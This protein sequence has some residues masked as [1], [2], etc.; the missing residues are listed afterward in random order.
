MMRYEAKHKFFTDSA[1]TSRNF[2]NITKTLSNRHQRYIS[3]KR[4]S[5]NNDIYIGKKTKLLSKYS[6]FGEYQE[7]LNRLVQC[8]SSSIKSIK[9]ININSNEYR[10]GLMILHEK[11]LFEIVYV[12][13]LD[14]NYFIFCHSYNVKR[15]D[16]PMN[17]FIIEKSELNSENIRLIQLDD[18]TFEKSFEKK[19]ANQHIYLIAESLEVFANLCT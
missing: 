12:L 11:N 14:S 3:T 8:D 19:Y 10:K 4:F 17:S 13:C 16:E 15:Y 7:L 2:I 18:L 9:F 6:D 5:Y 1:N